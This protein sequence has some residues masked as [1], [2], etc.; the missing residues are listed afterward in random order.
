M[1]RM[2]YTQY[3]HEFEDNKG[4][5]RYAVA[6]WDEAHAQYIRP[7][8][9]GERRDTGCFAE[10]ARKPSG[11]QSFSDRTR[12]LRRARYLFRPEDYDA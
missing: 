7:F 8:D 5:T 2:D 10:F 3:V 12:A 6:R 11:M 4:Q 1:A 9:A